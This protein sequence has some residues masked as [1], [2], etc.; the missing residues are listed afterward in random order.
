[1][2]IKKNQWASMTMLLVDG[3]RNAIYGGGSG[4]GGGRE[5]IHYYGEETQSPH[6]K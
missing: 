1:M 3:N 4:G 6:S 2:K 5:F